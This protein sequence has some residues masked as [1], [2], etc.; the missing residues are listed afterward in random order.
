MNNHECI[1]GKT[2]I[3]DMKKCEVCGAEFVLDPEALNFE[4]WKQDQHTFMPTCD[5][6]PKG[7]RLSIG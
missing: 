6:F 5:H 2:C 4:T 3:E 7:A 1:A